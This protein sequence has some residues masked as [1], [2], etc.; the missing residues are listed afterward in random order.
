VGLEQQKIEG[1][2]W[3]RL[4]FVPVRHEGNQNASVEEVECIAGLVEGL[5]Q[6]GV[7]WIDNK[8]R[9]RLLRLDDVLVVAPYNAQVSDLSNRLSDARVGTVDKFQGQ[10]APV[11]IYSMTTL[12]PEDAPRG[13]EFLYSLNGLNVATSRSLTC[14][15]SP[16][17][18]RTSSCRMSSCGYVDWSFLDRANNALGSRSWILCN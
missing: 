4:W 10:Q 5:V 6:S 14:A 7:N 1:H 17:I 15:F 12:S 2:P 16:S 13:M 18:C 9:S 11:V 3:L 8:G